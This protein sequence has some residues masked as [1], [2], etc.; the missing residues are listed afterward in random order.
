MVIGTQDRRTRTAIVLHWRV[1]AL[2]VAAGRQ[3]RGK[4]ALDRRYPYACRGIRHPALG[5]P[6]LVCKQ[7]QNLE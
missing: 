5:G 3:P 6:C 7:I 2:L 4:L 1:L